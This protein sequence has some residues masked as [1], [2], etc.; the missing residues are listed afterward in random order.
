MV[1]KG[2]TT[3]QRDGQ[4]TSREI[5][6]RVLLKINSRFRRDESKNKEDPVKYIMVSLFYLRNNRPR[7]K[8][9]RFEE[10]KMIE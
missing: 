9:Q 8:K 5:R 1:G 4:Q 10:E 3:E 2:N 7:Q 6:L